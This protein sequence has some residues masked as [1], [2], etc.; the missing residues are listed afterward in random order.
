MQVPDNE[1]RWRFSRSSGPGGQHVDASSTRVELSWDVAHTSVLSEVQ[2][3][4]ALTR[5]APRL[6]NGVLTVD[7]SEHRSQLRNREA[8]RARLDALVSD[9]VRPVKARRPTKPTKGSRR[10][11]IETKKRRGEIKRLRRPPL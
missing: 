4:R 10:R 3:E 1:L 9:A 6:T 8:A 7:A 11:R 2:R 5:L